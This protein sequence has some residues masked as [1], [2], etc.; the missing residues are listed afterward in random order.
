M[1]AADR[2]RLTPSLGIVAAVLLLVLI[3]LWLGLGSGAHWH[4]Q[5]APPKLPQAGINLPA[6]T[7]PPL[8]QYAAVWQ[9]PLF[10]PART[11]EAAAGNGDEAAGDLQLTGVIM[12]PNLKMAILHDKTNNRD[13]RII[14]GQPS[15]S[16]PAL[17]ELHPRGAVVESS[18]SRVN[19]QLIPGPPPDASAPAEDAAQPQQSAEQ[20]ASA[21][22]SRQAPSDSGRRVPMAGPGER[23]SAE[24]RARQ[25]K[26]RIEAARRRAARQHDDGG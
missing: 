23:S 3:T 26:A 7:V 5:A 2:R 24:A 11:P 1:N 15:R 10:N 17:I 18:G 14:E 25:L 16:G 21:M 19:L 9:H 22:V 20:G 13:Y 6:P 8:D 4:D 12:L